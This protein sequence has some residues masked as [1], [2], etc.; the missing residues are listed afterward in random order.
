MNNHKKINKLLAGFALGELSSKQKTETVKHLAGCDKCSSELKQID[1]LLQHTGH[2]TKLS[3]DNQAYESAKNEI[4]KVVKK[5]TKEQS[6]SERNIGPD[7]FL[8]KIINSKAIRFAAVALIVIGVLSG[9]T[10]WPNPDFQNVQWWLGPPAAWGQEIVAELD[11]IEALVYREQA[12]FVSRYGSTHVSGTWSRNYKAKDRYRKDRYYEDTDEDTYGDSSPTSVLQQVTYKIP[13]GHNLMEYNVSFEHQCYTIKTI[14]DGAYERDPIENLRSYVNQ[15]DKADRILDKATFE[16]RECVGFEIDTSKN[17]DNPT[18]RT[19]RIWFDVLTKLPV[20]IERHGLPVTGLPGETLT[21][22]R[23]QFEYYAQVPAEMFEPEIPVDFISAEPDEIR[24]AKE[25]Q[26][27]GQMLYANVPAG[28]KDEIAAALKSVNTAIYRQRFGFTKDGNWLLSDGET[29]YISEYDWRKDS[30]SSGQIQ[31]TEWYVTDKD[32]WGKTSFDFNDKNF[33]LIQ[34]TVNYA[35]HSYSQITHGSTSH[36]DNPM[37]RIIFLAGYIDK[38]DRFFESEQIDDVECFGFELSA[39]K[40]G[41]NPETSIHTLWFDAGTML[42]VKMELEWLED[43][44]S[45][46][47]IQDQFKWNAELPEE[48]FIPDIPAGFTLQ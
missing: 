4:Y 40:Y 29:I 42:P 36:P 28:L 16:G 6:N 13:D 46:K 47:I 30:L 39:K 41:T 32:D 26:E 48:T 35:D 44:G 21:F 11:R 24:T 2:L 8:K 14:K 3:V 45:R 37:D 27:K 15:L 43:D 23:D 34:T 19:D 17:D 31:K 22:I 7:A 25:K 12:V 10:F 20:R 33:R 38:A 5:E 1:A 18:G 9:V